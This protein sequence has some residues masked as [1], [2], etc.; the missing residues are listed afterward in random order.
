MTV[1]PLSSLSVPTSLSQ[2]LHNCHLRNPN[3]Q[4][5]PLSVFLTLQQILLSKGS[6][7]HP[8]LLPKPLSSPNM[9]HITLQDLSSFHFP[10]LHLHL[11]CLVPHICHDLPHSHPFSFMVFVTQRPSLILAHLVTA[12]LLQD[13][14]QHSLTQTPDMTQVPL[15]IFPNTH[16]FLLAYHSSLPYPSSA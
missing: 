2:F 6:S 15:L 11:I 10:T 13:S 9:A 7:N 16:F 8:S 5:A 1:L 14:D 12:T 3:L 4:P